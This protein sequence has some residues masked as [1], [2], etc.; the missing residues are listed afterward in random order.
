MTE[1][2][3]VGRGGVENVMETGIRFANILEIEACVWQTHAEKSADGV[4]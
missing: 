1:V 2:S 3:R 4:T